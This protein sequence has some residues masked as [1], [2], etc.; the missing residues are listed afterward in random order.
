MAQ[1]IELPQFL[2]DL[3]LEPPE[4]V[5]ELL[6]PGALAQMEPSKAL[7]V[8]MDV[9]PRFP[10]VG[11]GQLLTL[12]GSVTLFGVI[13]IP[14]FLVVQATK[15][16]EELAKPIAAALTLPFTGAFSIPVPTEEWEYG[17][18]GFQ[19]LAFAFPGPPGLSEPKFTTIEPVRFAATVTM[20]VPEA[21]SPLTIYRGE[22]PRNVYVD[23]T[24]KNAGNID[25]TFDIVRS[26]A[27]YT[28]LRT[29]TI[30]MGATYSPTDPGDS[31]S[32]P[33]TA[34]NGYYNGEVIV[35]HLGIELARDT[36]T[37][38][39]YIRDDPSYTASLTG[40][41]WTL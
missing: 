29:Q 33:T 36:K 34:V 7:K 1:Q 31:I 40:V 23:Y 9:S 19:V 13:G 39:V 15:R 38:I 22:L 16:P 32:M 26:L 11:R 27:P 6:Q 41:T 35:R 18:Y 8:T 28:G 21:T 30:A 4:F 2:K 3:Q 17:D 10:A 14:A 5:R 24:V 25:A 20:E 12:N 37:G